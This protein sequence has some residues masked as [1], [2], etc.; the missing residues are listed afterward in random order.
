MG[1]GKNKNGAFRVPNRQSH[2]RISFLYQAATYL[3]NI[4]YTTPESIPREQESKPE[5]DPLQQIDNSDLPFTD[6][7]SRK[8]ASQFALSQYYAS[9]IA[10]IARKAQFKISPSLKRTICKGCKV[11]LIPGST[12]TSAI[13]NLSRNAEKSWS[14][15]LIITCKLCGMERR[16]P[17]QSKGDRSGKR[18][19]LSRAVEPQ[20]TPS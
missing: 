13:E 10:T 15:V 9:Q 1:K 19:R 14:D 6:S 2:A 18:H 3:T 11:V 12:S 5:N 7:S 20:P 17:V 4:P 8:P 16:Y